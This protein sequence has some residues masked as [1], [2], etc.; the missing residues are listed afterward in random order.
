MTRTVINPLG[1]QEP[2]KTRLIRDKDGY[3]PSRRTRTIA[4]KITTSQEWIETF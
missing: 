3:K 2:L 1:E 4:N